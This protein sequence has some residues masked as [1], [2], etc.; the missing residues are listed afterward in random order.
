MWHAEDLM[1]LPKDVGRASE[2]K[3]AGAQMGIKHPHHSSRLRLR[4]PSP[5]LP[6]S[7]KPLNTHCFPSF[8]FCARAHTHTRS[9]QSLTSKRLLSFSNFQSK[10]HSSGKPGPVYTSPSGLSLYRLYVVVRRAGSSI[11]LHYV[12]TVCP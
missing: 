1:D 7:Q 4:R 3:K 5:R 8:S 11:R 6:S 9:L 10:D 12:L 2:N